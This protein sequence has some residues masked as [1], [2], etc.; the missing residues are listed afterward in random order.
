MLRTFETNSLENVDIN[1]KVISLQCSWIE[2]FYEENFYEWKVIS[3]H[4]TCITF[5]Q[6]FKFHTNL[7]YDAKLL[8]DFLKL[9]AGF[10]E[11][12]W[13]LFQTLY[14][15]SLPVFYPFFMV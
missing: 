1:L 8:A 10:I 4:I 12:F 3:L 13:Q 7:S 14:S 15:F 9:L 5:G 6:K 11:I 2:N